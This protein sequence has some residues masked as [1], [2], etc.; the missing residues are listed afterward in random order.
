MKKSIKRIAISLCSV[1]VIA[2]AAG[3]GG[4]GGKNKDGKTTIEFWGWGDY[5]EVDVFKSLVNTFNDAHDDIFVNFTPR[6]SSTYSVDTLKQLQ[7]RR[8]PDVVFVGDSDIKKW[9]SSEIDVLE[10]LTPY[11]EKSDVIDLDD[12]WE[13]Q[14]ARFVFD[15][16]TFENSADA[17]IWGLP[18]DLGATVIYY[19]AD[20]IKKA[21]ITIVEG[22]TADEVPADEAKGFYVKDGK[23]YFNNSIPMTQTQ[24][25][26]MGKVLTK[27]QNPSAPTDFGYYCQ[28]WFNFD[29][30]V[31]GDDVAY[32]ETDDPAY[33][34]G[35]Y[36]FVL[37][38]KAPNYRV[39][40][41]ET[42]SVNG[43]AYQG[44]EL[45]SYHDR[46][47]LTAEQKGQCNELASI[48]E[49][50]DFWVSLATGKDAS[51]KENG[52]KISP[53]P[54]DNIDSTMFTNQRLAMYVEGRYMVPEFR[55]DCKFNWD[56]APLAL[57]EGGVE[58]GHS[59]S[60]CISMSKNSKNKDAAFELIE[61]L[62]GPEGQKELMK[63][64]FNVP[65]QKSIARSDAFL[66]SDQP[67]YNNAVFVRA[68]EVQRGGDWTYLPDDAWI[69]EWAPTLN[70]DVLNGVVT[71]D[72]LFARYTATVNN[73]LKT[74]TQVK[75]K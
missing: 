71:V 63:T 9:A 41:G 5:I 27:D 14:M 59:G 46:A 31:G 56:V 37:N 65:N 66:V 28:W 2:A 21:G 15:Q 57:W 49:V 54:N 20:A 62:S 67:P 29:W 33:K 51:G 64:G 50:F 47:K 61:Y 55:R 53:N 30:S 34:G 35:Y 72:Q 26:E 74:Y 70:G 60:M 68:A 36:E 69:E 25:V 16:E 8:P 52:N 43:T 17:P 1:F 32:M 40:E 23:M 38:D 19:N 22:K 75:N 39:K 3:C 42:L 48:R 11:V 73:K 6:P 44:G 7:S 4:D 24:L 13:G 12:I 10:D 45:I 58:A 18:K